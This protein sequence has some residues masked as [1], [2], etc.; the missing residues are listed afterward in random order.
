MKCMKEKEILEM[1][2]IKEK[3]AE[4][5][6]MQVCKEMGLPTTPLSQPPRPMLDV[7]H[8]DSPTRVT[9]S[10][11]LSI[12]RE[13]LEIVDLTDSP[14]T[15]TPHGD[16]QKDTGYVSPAPTTKRF[17]TKQDLQQTFTP[18]SKA[19]KSS[20]TQLFSPCKPSGQSAKE[21]NT[22]EIWSSEYMTS[23]SCVKHN[24]MIAA[25]LFLFGKSPKDYINKLW[26]VIEDN[27]L[28][29][30]KEAITASAE[31]TESFFNIML[32]YIP[33]F[34]DG[35]GSPYKLHRMLA[36]FSAVNCV[37]FS[38]VSICHLFTHILFL[39][40]I[41][42]IFHFQVTFTVPLSVLSF[43]I[44]FHFLFIFLLYLYYLQEL[45]VACSH[46]VYQ[47]LCHSH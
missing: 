38:E 32:K 29:V 14:P 34:L 28:L 27:N 4:E 44:N 22:L 31:D 24:L 20:C 12:K 26:S 36:W 30:E 9:P 15:N 7:H 43:I 19:G 25:H 41:F 1:N 42:F 8:H 21:E 23:I 5:L 40:F 2:E 39:G 17:A 6:E 13:K 45:P 47:N 10:S 11:L 46:L 16:K 37:S 33:E 18:S 3:F 35:T